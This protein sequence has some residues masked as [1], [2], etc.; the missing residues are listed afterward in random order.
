MRASSRP[1]Y[2]C[3]GVLGLTDEQK[4]IEVLQ[5]RL[6]LVKDN[7]FKPRA[8][9]QAAIVKWKKDFR[10][11]LRARPLHYRVYLVY[12]GKILWKVLEVEGEPYE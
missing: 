5:N 1:M 10:V 2:I 6:S 3:A 11:E 4:Q 9:I 7:K 12:S 8:S